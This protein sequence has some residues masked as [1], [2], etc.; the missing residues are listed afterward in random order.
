[1]PPKKKQPPKKQPPKKQPAKRKQLT[2]REEL[3]LEFKKLQNLR[4]MKQIELLEQQKKLKATPQAPRMAGS[5]RESGGKN[6][7]P[8]P[9]TTNVP[10]SSW[11]GGGTRQASAPALSPHWLSNSIPLNTQPLVKSDEHVASQLEAF[12]NKKMTEQEQRMMQLFGDSAEKL[13]ATTKTSTRQEPGA[14]HAMADD[15]GVVVEETPLKEIT[16]YR[17]EP[18]LISEV[19]TRP[20]TATPIMMMESPITSSPLKASVRP[21]V[22]EPFHTPRPTVQMEVDTSP[23]R[24]EVVETPPQP[25][26]PS[27]IYR[28]EE[29]VQRLYNESLL[30]YFRINQLIEAGEIEDSRIEHPVIRDTSSNYDNYKRL[31]ANLSNWKKNPRFAKAFNN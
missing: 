24:M 10:I 13:K 19:T 7:Q 9:G 23:V 1:M 20:V 15:T 18:P 21:S 25:T 28:S 31:H 4:V 14:Y 2:E 8:P 6:Y 22:A 3:E 30:A 12:L 17:K 27:Q 29:S 26:R 16:S 11:L 5:R